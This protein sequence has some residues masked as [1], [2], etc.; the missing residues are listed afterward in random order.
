MYSEHDRLLDQEIKEGGETDGLRTE[1]ALIID[2]DAM[3]TDTDTP[4][5]DA[6]RMVWDIR[7]LDTINKHRV[8]A[9]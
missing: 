2:Q 7:E 1:S 8:K 4:E 9:G 6:N 3:M 5:W